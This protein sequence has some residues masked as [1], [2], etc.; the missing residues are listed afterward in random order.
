[1]W[2]PDTRTAAGRMVLKLQWS[3]VRAERGNMPHIL[4]FLVCWR[5]IWDD[6]IRLR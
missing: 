2:K 6:I 3:H 1:M 4:Q 5:N